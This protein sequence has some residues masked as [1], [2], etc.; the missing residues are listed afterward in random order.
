VTLW[1]APASSISALD[2]D[3]PNS[4]HLGESQGANAVDWSSYDEP[5]HHPQRIREFLRHERRLIRC[6]ATGYEN[7][8]ELGCGAGRYCEVIAGAGAE[9]VGVDFSPDLIAGGK[10]RFGSLQNVRFELCDVASALTNM[11]L[12]YGSSRAEGTLLFFP[13]NFLGLSLPYS[14]ILD[15][16][17]S[18]NVDFLA[19]FYPIEPDFTQARL[20]YYARCGLR[21]VVEVTNDDGVW[22]KPRLGPAVLAPSAAMLAGL[23]DSHSLSA[24]SFD[25]PDFRAWGRGAWVDSVW[26][27][28]TCDSKDVSP[29]V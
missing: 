24:E 9:Y 22:L 28:C 13:F 12:E 5:G 19:S 26:R 14:P 21:D 29:R 20:D 17:S 6:I 1:S 15:R 8:T 10:E 11:S 3:L 7:V 25:G 27:S 4:P 18:L 23:S 2:E 16:L